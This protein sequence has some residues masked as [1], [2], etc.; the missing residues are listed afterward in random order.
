MRRLFAVLE[1]R[2]NVSFVVILILL[3]GVIFLASLSRNPDEVAEETVK[4]P[5]TSRIFPVRESGFI[6]ATAKVKKSGVVDIIAV[7]GGTVQS[8]HVRVGQTVGTGTTLVTLTNDYGVN[9]T[10]LSAEKTRLESEFTARVF[11]LQE[12]INRREQKIADDNDELT[13]REEK[14]AIQALKVELERLRLNRETARL[15]AQ[16]ANASDAILRPKSLAAGTVEF[17]G[18][19]T[20]ENINAG[21]LIATIRGSK[22]VDTL[23]AS[24]PNEIARF[25]NPNGVATLVLG[26]ER[27]PLSQGYLSQGENSLGL[28][29][30]TFPLTGESAHKLTES[31]F[32]NILLPLKN[33]AHQFFV[34]IDAILSGAAGDSVIVLGANNLAEEKSI[35]LGDTIG[36]FVMV[37]SGLGENDEVIMNRSIA[38]GETVERIQ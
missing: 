5:K 23:T 18:V 9:A 1:K 6:T 16:I 21:T 14:N 15:D 26:D 27:L 38:P 33:N 36:S 3:F 32:V 24:L 10:R 4:A 34:P 22:S 29:S 17:I 19:R 37:K 35:V 12:E 25:L 30:L 11:S 31:E 2:P 7:T 20:G 8:V 28:R 13:D